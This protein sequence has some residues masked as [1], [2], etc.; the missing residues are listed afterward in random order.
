[1]VA[2]SSCPFAPLLCFL[3]LFLFLL[4]NVSPPWCLL[5]SPKES[6]TNCLS[7]TSKSL[8]LLEVLLSS[9]VRKLLVVV[10][11]TFPFEDEDEDE[12]S[13]PLSSLSFRFFRSTR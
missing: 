1:M 11:A 7:S 4:V 12:L 13:P 5:R 6:L 10:V 9:V 8:L 3:F 2:E